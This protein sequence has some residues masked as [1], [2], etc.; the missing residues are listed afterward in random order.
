M[1]LR[2]AASEA[3]VRAA[4][5]G[6]ETEARRAELA[7]RR[8]VFGLMSEAGSAEENVARL[9]AMETKNGKKLA[10]MEAEWEDVRAPLEEERAE[11]EEAIRAS[12]VSKMMRRTIFFQVT[13]RIFQDVGL[14][15][16]EKTLQDLLAKTSEAESRL[17]ECEAAIRKHSAAVA[18][19][20]GGGGGGGGRQEEQRSSYTRR[21]LDVLSSIRKQRAET[22][23]VIADIRRTQKDINLL[24]GKLD[25][26]Y[27]EA[28]YKVF[29]VRKRESW[30]YRRYPTGQE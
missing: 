15:E 7:R 21:I 17:S 29:E 25:R 18:K 13:A 24:E 30:G 12:K 28:D 20:D 8:K 11:I 6:N 23:R 9:R 2:K 26:T 10:A 19:L 16:R 27:G 5:I 3:E 1:S 14:S 22:E 4:K